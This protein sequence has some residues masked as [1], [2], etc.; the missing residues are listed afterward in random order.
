M[1]H[2]RTNP[3]FFLALSLVAL[4]AAGCGGGGAQ[5]GTITFN[6]R[7]LTPGKVRT[8]TQSDQITVYDSTGKMVGQKVVNEA[9][10]HS[11]A[12]TFTGIHLGTF[13]YH[14]DQYDGT[15]LTGAKI[16]T[17]EAQGTIGSTTPLVIDFRADKPAEGIA[18]TPV[19]P[20]MA[21][22]STMLFSA[23]GLTD[24]GKLTFL[25]PAGA[26]WTSDNAAVS[27][28]AAGVATAM[29]PGTAT[30][31]ATDP[32]FGI[33]G[34]TLVTVTSPPRSKWTIMVYLD[35]ANDLQP[36][37]ILNMNQME[38][39]GN[40]T[41]ARFVV[42]WK[43]FKATSPGSTFD[44]TR[45]YLVEKDAGNSVKS[46]LISDLGKNVDMGKAATMR[47]FVDWAKVH[48]PSDHTMLVMWDHGDGW[49]KAFVQKQ[50]RAIHS[51]DQ[52]FSVM[53][54]WDIRTA[55]QGQHVD[56]VATDACEM[57]QV[58]IANEWRSFCDFL[59]GSEELTPGP[60]YVYQNCFKLF[61]TSP[62]ADVVSLARVICDK[63][64]DDHGY[65][66][67]GEQVTQSVADLS[68]LTALNS[69][70]GNFADTLIANV[71]A[72]ATTMEHV[73]TN[74]ERY[75]QLK[76]FQFYYDLWD[77]CAKMN[78]SATCPMAVKDAAAA[79]QAAVTD[80]IPYYRHSANRP[81]GH[82]IA[83]DLSPGSQYN[84]AAYGNLQFAMN[85]HWSAWLA[86]AP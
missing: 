84:A 49:K 36:E 29:A 14:L 28:T 3:V 80:A 4:I 79:V 11:R 20:T 78:E 82:G 32:S 64:V 39:L 15:N 31:T 55:M 71:G 5:S 40:S 56:V 1:K 68:K 42:Q 53:D 63:Q 27:I 81:A 83:I 44:G 2:L 18:V 6:I 58:D 22:D 51:D 61:F 48:Y 33:S 45:R 38:L 67:S 47:Q 37:S 34:S 75:D 8:A 30:I 25:G 12:A 9:D 66:S 35:A 24:S 10:G 73:R 46:T 85:N 65:M 41:D 60:G 19:T 21:L 23:Q 7:W 77:V 69:A 54:V 26:T 62:D 76:S 86:I 59:V 52:F 74:S 72:M 17:S 57:Q 50:T 16:G 13:R 70:I 43:Q